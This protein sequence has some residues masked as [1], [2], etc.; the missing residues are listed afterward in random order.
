[1]ENQKQDKT[2]SQKPDFRSGS[3]LRV[4]KVQAPH[5]ARQKM[6]PLI[7]QIK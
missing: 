4:G 1:M 6:V 5:N 3:L 7:K 2:S